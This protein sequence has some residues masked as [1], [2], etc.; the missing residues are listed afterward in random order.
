M[1][2]RLKITGKDTKKVLLKYFPDWVSEGQGDEWDQVFEL[3][4]IIDVIDLDTVYNCK[5]DYNVDIK[6]YYQRCDKCVLE[7]P[8]N[9]LYPIQ[10]P[11]CKADMEPIRCRVEPE[12]TMQLYK[13]AFPLSMWK[14]SNKSCWG[15]VDYNIEERK[16]IPYRTL[17]VG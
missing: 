5:F 13:K 9:C 12:E 2:I 6:L 10:C 4:D 16:Y 7:H 17:V 3:E 1:K 14:C 8:P 15:R 11:L